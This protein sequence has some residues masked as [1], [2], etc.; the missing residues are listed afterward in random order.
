MVFPW[1]SHKNFSPTGRCRHAIASISCRSTEPPVAVWHTARRSGFFFWGPQGY[2]FSGL[3]YLVYNGIYKRNTRLILYQIYKPWYK[4]I[5]PKNIWAIKIPGLYFTNLNS[6]AYF[7]GVNLPILTPG[8]FIYEV[9]TSD[10]GG[11]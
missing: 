9:G 11:S 4:Y 1:F 8:I 7:K 6:S 5:Y 10:F 3:K 2:F